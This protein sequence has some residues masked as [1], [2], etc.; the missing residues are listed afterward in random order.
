MKG[1]PL[2]E[3]KTK[4][5]PG[6]Q[7][8]DEAEEEE[9]EVKK[10]DEDESREREEEEEEEE[11]VV[12]E[13]GQDMVLTEVEVEV[14]EEDEVEVGE[15][16]NPNPR[17]SRPL[18]Q[19]ISTATIANASFADFMGFSLLENYVD[20]SQQVS[21]ESYESSDEQCV[22]DP[23]QL[24]LSYQ[25]ASAHPARI[26]KPMSA[27]LIWAHS[28]RMQLRRRLPDVDNRDISRILGGMWRQLTEEQRH[29]YR[30]RSQQLWQNFRSTADSKTYR[31][32]RM[33]SVQAGPAELE[34]MMA[35][36][37]QEEGSKK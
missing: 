7:K 16:L 8:A 25:E 33:R 30:V 32:R 29:P 5:R 12:V 4:M 36:A 1:R 28:R 23:Q 26:R 14:E 37:L 13:E 9:S 24:E 15:D 3:N 31:Y 17:I 18:Q 22:P 35:A 27:F 21:S 6:H 2:R 11:V 19:E 10:Q 20:A 34:K